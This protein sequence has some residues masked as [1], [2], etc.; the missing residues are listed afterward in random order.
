MMMTTKNKISLGK[1]D[2]KIR[3]NQ[4]AI[5]INNFRHLVKSSESNNSSNSSSIV[6]TD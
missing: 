4:K 5:R 6:T 2:N 1:S 3:K